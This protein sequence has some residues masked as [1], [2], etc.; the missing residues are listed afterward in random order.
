MPT[1]YLTLKITDGTTTADLNDV[2]NYQLVEKGWAPTVAPLR[3]ATLGG[4]GSY[5]DVAEEIV[6]NVLGSSAGLC[7]ANLAKL[8]QLLDQAERW[9][10]GENVAAVRLQCQPLGSMLAAPLECVILGRVAQRPLLGLPMTF[11]DKLGIQIY[12]VP[13]VKLNFLRRG[14]WLEAAEE[15]EQMEPAGMPNPA[16]VRS[17][18]NT[19]APIASPVKAVLNFLLDSTDITQ[20]LLLWANSAAR[21]VYVEAEGMAGYQFT[22]VDDTAKLARGTDVLRYTPTDLVSTSAGWLALTLPTTCRRV[23][24]WAAVRNNSALATW[25]IRARLT[26]GT[27]NPTYYTPEGLIDTASQTPRIVFLGIIAMP[28]R[29]EF[30]NVYVQASTLTGLPTLDI[31]YFTVLDITD[32]MAGA[33]LASLSGSGSAGTA[34]TIDAQ[35]LTQ[36]TAI[37]TKTVAAG[38]ANMSYLGDAFMA[39]TSDEL[40]MTYLATE[41]T[42][43]CAQSSGAP[44]IFNLT[45][46]RWQ[47]HTTPE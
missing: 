40:A 9:W 10:R 37:V 14:L 36:P 46:T 13:S 24:I 31:D 45:A 6:V 17:T 27:S 3:R 16:V 29:P 28:A 8:S 22:A 18:F 35:P 32:E 11:H 2:L 25:N 12:E 26:S 20:Y 5:E 23:A 15:G 34:I 19:L 43:W 1:E 47:A 39:V 7:L 44:D 21:I 38:V 4:S 30:L 42:Y 41:A 33:V